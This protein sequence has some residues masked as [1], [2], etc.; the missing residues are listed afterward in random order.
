MEHSQFAI[1]HI[2]GGEWV[3]D[4]SG[5]VII[6]PEKSDAEGFRMLIDV[7]P[8]L[9]PEMEVRAFGGKLDTVRYEEI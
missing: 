2:P 9:G 6:F 4:H 5:R 7:K 1:W 8:P 3:T